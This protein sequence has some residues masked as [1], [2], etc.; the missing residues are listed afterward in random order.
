MTDAPV[1]SIG[2]NPTR[3]AVLQ[4]RV[5]LLVGGVLVYNSVE[6]VIALTAGFVASSTALIGFGLDSIVEVTSALAVTWQY[7]HHR[8]P[9]REHRALRI[10]AW[11]FFALAAYVTI[12][13]ITTLVSGDHADHSP[14]GLTLTA[15]SLI[16]MPV[17]SYLE[18]STGRELGSVSVIADSKQTLLC[19]YLSAIVL[20]GLILNSTLGWS[21]ADPIAGLGVA[22]LAVKE[23]R[24]A[25]R[26]DVCCA[27]PALLTDAPDACNDECCE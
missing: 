16:L 24:N 6:A 2:P 9:D 5:R 11:S 18:R 8:P 7:A 1:L 19:T 3:I 13:A 26:G 22:F 21:W 27:S 12:D 17:V 23:G 10:I 25:L 4:R 15:V 20:G 14:V